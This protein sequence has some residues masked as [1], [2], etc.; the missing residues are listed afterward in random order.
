ME[1]KEIIK[2]YNNVVKYLLNNLDKELYEQIIINNEEIKENYS[3]FF[4]NQFDDKIFNLLSRLLQYDKNNIECKYDLLNYLISEKEKLDGII[5]EF[6][7]I[8]ECNNNA[9]LASLYF[10]GITKLINY[11]L[12]F[13]KK[14][15]ESFEEYEINNNE[16]E[17]QKIEKKKIESIQKIENLK[18]KY[19][20]MKFEEINEE[21]K[22]EVNMED[23]DKKIEKTISL[24]IGIVK[25]ILFEMENAQR[26]FYKY[27]DILKNFEKYFSPFF[28]EYLYYLKTFLTKIPNTLQMFK[29]KKYNQYNDNNDNN[30]SKIQIILN[31]KEL[32]YFIFILF[33]YNFNLHYASMSNLI[34]QFEYTFNEKTNEIKNS[35]KFTF[36]IKGEMLVQKFLEGTPKKLL[37]YKN[38]CIP[39]FQENSIYKN[40]YLNEKYLLF[41]SCQNNNIFAKYKNVYKNFFQQI[42]KK[43]CIKNLF[44]DIF[45]Y[46][47]ENFFIDDAFIEDLFDNKINA[48]NFESRDFSAETISPQLK[49]YIKN[50]YEG[51][52]TLECEICVFVAF[53]ILIFHELAHYIRIYIFKITKEQKYKSSIDLCNED[54]IGVYL[55]KLL[56]GD[57]INLIN[58]YQAMFLL[59]I[60]NYEMEYKEF[61]KNFQLLSHDKNFIESK[62]EDLLNITE[63]NNFLNKLDIKYENWNDNCGTNYL[64]IKGNKFYIGIN[65]DKTG[66]P[67]D[68]KIILQHF[69]KKKNK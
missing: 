10:Y 32:D 2:N 30:I 35:N 27:Q 26:E 63:C 1:K 22:N 14:K 17:K 61:S 11:S 18:K 6:P 46:L 52:D 28:E 7:I 23:F 48:Y 8:K 57:N 50:Y 47:N 41:S 64:K 54:E 34:L 4:E 66:R 12:N 19:N 55:E 49:I 5:S 42:F 65:N 43:K 53:I 51:D 58:F 15:N 67:I 60:N 21:K 20:D 69:G 9:Y 33:N 45:P 3:Y 38:Y 56:F 39:L 24:K 36:E 29:N 44:S 62:K 37:N 68:L 13:G 59:N 40:R 31:L 25:N 16:I